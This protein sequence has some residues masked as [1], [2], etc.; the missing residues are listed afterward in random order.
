MTRAAVVS[1]RNYVWLEP[2][3]YFDVIF[4]FFM[5][6]F[7]EHWYNEVDKLY[8]MDSM[9]D[10]VYDD[11]KVKI[12]KVDGQLRYYEAY[13]QFLP[14]IKEDLVLFL[15]NDMVIAESGRVASAFAKLEE[16]YDVVTI[17][18]TIGTWATDQLKLGNKFCPYF[19]ATKKDLLMKFRYS[20]WEPNMPEYETLGDLTRDMVN[21]GVKVLEIQDDKEHPPVNPDFYHIRAG[22]AIAYLLTTKHSNS[23]LEYWDYLKL[24][25]ES[26]IMRHCDWY[27]RM[28]GS[29][30]ELRNDLAEAV[31]RRNLENGKGFDY[32]E[33]DI[34]AN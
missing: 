7:K 27:D 31:S 8:I 33:K 34:T 5:K 1:F 10:A 9:W 22:S 24:Q 32:E 2:H 21:A 28:G 14:K 12:V 16:G 11:P 19:F 29:T 26:E 20:H 23:A 6:N 18:D 17:M 13:K 15:D 4:D 30:K 25:P 3:K